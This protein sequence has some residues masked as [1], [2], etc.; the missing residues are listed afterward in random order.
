MKKTIAALLRKWANQL[1]PQGGGGPGP[2][3][4]DPK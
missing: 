1:D 4:E 2:R 3:P